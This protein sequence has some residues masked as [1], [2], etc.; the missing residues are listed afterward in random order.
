M[1]TLITKNAT[2]LRFDKYLICFLVRFVLEIE[3]FT[4]QIFS[5]FTDLF[6]KL[7]GSILTVI[8]SSNSKT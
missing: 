1:K 7:F 8:E 5:G 4:S 2:H 3:T 6:L